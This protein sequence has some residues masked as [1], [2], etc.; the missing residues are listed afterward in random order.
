MSSMFLLDDIFFNKIRSIKIFRILL[1][2]NYRK[3]L[4]INLILN[5]LGENTVY[6]IVFNFAQMCYL[7]KHV[8]KGLRNILRL[9]LTRADHAGNTSFFNYF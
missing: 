3:R 4:N 1:F 5:L 7:S 2:S 9:V 8:R 6:L